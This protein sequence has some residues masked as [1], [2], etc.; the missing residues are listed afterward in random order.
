VQPKQ[1]RVE[2]FTKRHPTF[3]SDVTPEDVD[4]T[5]QYLCSSFEE[6]GML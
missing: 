6:N 5:I 1:H 3:V 4:T 2:L